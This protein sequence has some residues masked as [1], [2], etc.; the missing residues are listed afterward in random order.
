[1]DLQ[2]LEGRPEMSISISGVYLDP[3]TVLPEQVQI[4]TT[5]VTTATQS[6]DSVDDDVIT[7]SSATKVQKLDKQGEP[8][9]QIAQSLGI[10]LT[11]VEVDLGVAPT[12]D[13]PTGSGGASASRAGS[14]NTSSDFGTSAASG[15]GSTSSNHVSTEASSV[16]ATNSGSTSGATRALG[17]DAAAAGAAGGSAS[18][19]KGASSTPAAEPVSVAAVA[20]VA[21]IPIP[22][23]PFA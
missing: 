21:A 16:A 3:S 13:V 12:I 23:N 22:R 20:Q 1:M 18:S 11:T 6:V 9:Q 17:S 8:P 14:A 4:P 10:S 7:L 2:V 5:T 15:A 19:A